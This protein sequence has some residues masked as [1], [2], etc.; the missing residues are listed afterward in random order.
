MYNYGYY[1]AFGWVMSTNNTNY[2][3]EAGFLQIVGQ[4]AD[5][6]Q[7]PMLRVSGE[8]VKTFFMTYIYQVAHGT[9]LM[10]LRKPLEE[11]QCPETTYTTITMEPEV[12]MDHCILIHHMVAPHNDSIKRVL[13][14][15]LQ[16]EVGKASNRKGVQEMVEAWRK[17]VTELMATLVHEANMWLAG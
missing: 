2:S 1:E 12:L 3:I 10:V 5:K 11:F 14:Q 15:H 6:S 9:S 4:V 7:I 8:V 17:S 16:M 13:K